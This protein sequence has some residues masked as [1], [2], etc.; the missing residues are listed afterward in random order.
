MRA[1]CDS[2]FAR[3][4]TGAHCTC[5]E[6]DDTATEHAPKR[7]QGCIGMGPVVSDGATPPQGFI[8]FISGQEI[9]LREKGSAWMMGKTTWTMPWL[10]KSIQKQDLTRVE[11]H[12]D[13]GIRPE[14]GIQFCIDYVAC[15]DN[16]LEHVY[17]SALSIRA[18]LLVYY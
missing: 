11:A 14:P 6:S 7:S 8:D 12:H 4:G 15:S 16:I 5:L 17:R 13:E 10:L 18:C 9:R 2:H 3:A 1:L